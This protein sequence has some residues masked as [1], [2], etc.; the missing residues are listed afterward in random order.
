MTNNNKKGFKGG[1]A[2]KAS[3]LNNKNKSGQKHKLSVQKSV[4]S[5]N[6]QKTA[7]NKLGETAALLLQH[8]GGALIDSALQDLKKSKIKPVSSDFIKK[9]NNNKAQRPPTEGIVTEMTVNLQNAL[10]SHA[11][12]MAVT[13]DKDKKAQECSKN[14]LEDLCDFK[15]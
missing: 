5:K 7:S 3:S 12:A 14:L 15:L 9:N 6:E 10:E 11:N 1:H 2:S 8:S 4:K 13:Y